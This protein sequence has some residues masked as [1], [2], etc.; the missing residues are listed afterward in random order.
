MMSFPLSCLLPSLIPNLFSSPL[1]PV[2]LSASP[3]LLF[4]TANRICAYQHQ[5]YFVNRSIPATVPT[6]DGRDG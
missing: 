3:F 1:S 5:C 2:A 4:F 6:A